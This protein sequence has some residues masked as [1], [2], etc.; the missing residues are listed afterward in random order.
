LNLGGPTRS[1]CAAPPPQKIYND[2]RRTGRCRSS[3]SR[4]CS[5]CRSSERGSNRCNSTVGCRGSDRFGRQ[6]TRRR[7]LSKQKN[8][9]SGGRHAPATNKRSYLR[10]TTTS[11]WQSIAA[12]WEKQ[13]DISYKVMTSA[14]SVMGRGRNHYT[15]LPRPVRLQS[16]HKQVQWAKG[17]KRP[18]TM[19]MIMAAKMIALLP[20]TMR[21]MTRD[22][23]GNDDENACPR[24]VALLCPLFLFGKSRS[25]GTPPNRTFD[26]K[27][28]T[29]TPKVA[30]SFWADRA[31]KKR[32][33]FSVPVTYHQQFKI[34]YLRRQLSLSTRSFYGCHD[35]SRRRLN[36]SIQGWT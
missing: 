29:T 22:E 25:I 27:D 19:T 5:T 3:I 17:G 28:K 13:H 1:R 11:W 36:L 26:V 34:L 9:G 10:R 20:E 4:S 8:D 16:Q 6:H 35:G 7:G 23:H 33:R 2:G 14:V 12:E 31:N 18:S 15:R 30:W 32:L 24:H 21:T